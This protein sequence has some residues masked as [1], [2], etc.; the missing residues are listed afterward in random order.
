MG[1]PANLVVEYLRVSDLIPYARNSRTHTDEQV[2]QVAASIR[3]FGFANPILISE[4]NDIIAG[5]CRAKAAA[6][7]GMD[8]VPCIRLGHLTEAQRKA[9]VI[10]DNRL[11]LNARWDVDMLALEL[12]ELKS[13]DLDLQVLGFNDAEL[14]GLLDSG[15]SSA[16]PNRE[17]KGMPEFDQEDKTGAK[18]LIVHFKTTEDVESFA[19]LVGQTV[20]EKTRSIW[21]PKAEIERYM[22]KRYEAM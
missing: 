22:D 17:W 15:E 3:E 19:R 6:K 1:E 7:L 14:A 4:R 13:A 20:T 10:A 12:V 8:L 2:A 11:A 16:D 21:F 5:H 18:Q 9:L